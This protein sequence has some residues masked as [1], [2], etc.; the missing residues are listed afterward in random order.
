MSAMSAPPDFDELPRAL[1]WASAEQRA[2]LSS[3]RASLAA[4]RGAG[5]FVPGFRL[6]ALDERAP[7]RLWRSAL[8]SAGLA[9]PEPHLAHC[10]PGGRVRVC[11]AGAG[12][13][14][15]S[16]LAR[17][18]GSAELAR[19]FVCAHEWAH[20]WHERAGRPLCARA[21][22]L[23]AS[24]LA[25]SARLGMLGS[26]RAS[27]GPSWELA[28]AAE[29]AFCDASACFALRLMGEP[30]ALMRVAA[31]RKAS[32]TLGTSA[33]T[34]HNH[35]ALLACSQAVDLCENFE[36]FA[37]ACACACAAAPISALLFGGPD[38]LCSQ[39]LPPLAY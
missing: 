3:A 22:S 4:L 7:A 10:L 15:L 24:P 33:R 16:V 28:K 36:S 34:H 29:E 9:P 39:T 31:F 12:A 30:D 25:E 14:L 23:S 8:R 32:A 1:P 18:L 27:T 2:W 21:A 17:V 26:P 6:A 11:S 19:R 5:G 20:A 13:E 37:D 35:R 38:G